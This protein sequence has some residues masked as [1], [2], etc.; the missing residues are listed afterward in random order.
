MI[1]TY[2]SKTP[3]Q[4]I[5]SCLKLADSR[6]TIFGGYLRDVFDPS[7]VDHKFKD[8]DILI[9]NQ[10]I[11]K[12]IDILD[13]AG[14]IR[15]MEKPIHGVYST[16]TLHTEINGESLVMDVSILEGHGHHKEWCDFTCNNLCKVVGCDHIGQSGG[17]TTRVA[18]PTGKFVGEYW[19]AKCLQDIS[20]HTLVLMCP[21]EWLIMNKQSS[22]EHRICHIRLIQRTMKMMRRGWKLGPSLNGLNLNFKI[23]N[24]TDLC[25]ICQEKMEDVTGIVLTCKHAFHIDCIYRMA[26]EDGPTSYS[27]PLCREHISFEAPQ[28]PPKPQNRR[29]KKTPSDDNS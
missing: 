25:T 26:C 10:G 11:T 1:K 7:N 2:E 6:S 21:G 14:F 4:I 18:D 8:L 27:C 28:N 20:S 17:I 12:F 23:Y 24:G 3:V 15:S 13:A 9:T 22:R 19:L 29:K 16:R 5:E